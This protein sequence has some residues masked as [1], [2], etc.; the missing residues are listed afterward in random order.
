[1]AYDYDAIIVG[2]RCAGASTALLLARQGHR[3]LLVDRAKFPSEIA[4][5]H[6][7]HRH[8]PRR[9]ARWG[10]LDKIVDSGCPP[11]TSMLWDL[12]DFPLLV[13]NLVE[14]GIAWGY[15]PRRGVL[16]KILVDAAVDAGAELQEQ[17]SAEDLLVEDGVVVGV[18]GRAA[19]HER[20]IAVRARLTIGADGLHSR[21]A[22]AVQAPEYE[23]VPTLACWY[24]SYW[25]GVPNQVMEIH[26][27]QRRRVVFTFP[28][29]DDLF[30]VF[31]GWPI[32]EFSSVR[33]DVE[34]AFHEVL[35]HIDGL[36][37]RLRMARRVERFYGTGDM[38][39]LFRKP[40]GPG[41]ALV[42]DA[43]LHK[44][45]YLALGIADALRDADYLAAAAHRGF[46]GAQPMDVALQS[47]QQQRDA[48]T[49]DDYRENVQMARFL[50]MPAEAL[51]LRA[52][53]RYQPEQATRFMKVRY[54]MLPPEAFSIQEVM[55]RAA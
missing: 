45:P 49:I 29:H 11:V 1:M 6:F 12:G 13:E 18:Q 43:G 37:E 9:L 38:P 10:L 39:N 28:T 55:A 21:V 22:R 32:E 20:S 40:F 44:D 19:G 42:G 47:Y 5:G 25:S 46:A 51:Q 16:D 26:A 52:A 35:D 15:G 30:A 53:L 54:G 27:L 14:D 7:I 48:S 34:S 17:F 4:R 3:V 23:T 24:F 33:A 2:A 31:I 50:A 8:G 41:W 36:G